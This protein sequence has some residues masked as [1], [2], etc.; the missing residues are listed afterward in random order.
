MLTVAGLTRAELGARL[1][2]P[3]LRLQTGRFVTSILSSID[4]VADGIA[5]MYADYPVHEADAFADFYVHLDRSTGLRRWYRPQ[6]LFNY[7][8]VT[9]FLP[10]PLHHA[11]PM[12]EWMLNWCIS[13]RAHRYL[14]LHA[15]V[16][17]RNGVAAILPAPPGSGKSTLCAALVSRGWRL[18]SDELTLVQLDNGALQ[19]LPRPVSLKNASIDLMRAYAPQGV[20]SRVVS[21]TSKGAVAHM[22]APT[23]SVLRAAEPARAAWIIFPRYVAGAAPLLAP[24][25]P[26]RAF[27]RVAENSF[28]YSL[29]AGAGFAALTRLVDSTA[30]YDF[31][32]SALDDA[33]DV[34]NR[35]E[36]P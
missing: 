8:G 19:P 32:Y 4:S 17:E 11:F 22:K 29:L 2:H 12:L 16:V 30:T 14:L 3:G 31:T 25:A 21:D 7:D 10:L 1:A 23:D 33:I 15:A 28:N 5:L 36:V 6:V 26:A 34:F 13:T 24:V 18:L 27:M 35:L 9:P 20:F